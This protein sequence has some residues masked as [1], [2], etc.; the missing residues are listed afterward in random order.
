MPVSLSSANQSIVA[1]ALDV[2]T[3]ALI[4]IGVVSTGEPANAEDAAWGLEKL[5][6]SIDQHNARR[7]MIFSIGLTLFNLQA[8]H[9]PHTIGP[10]GDFNL[11]TRPP[12][13]TAATFILNPGSAN[14][15]D[16]PIRIRDS[17]W[18]AANPLKSLSTSIVT[19]LYYDPALTLGQLNFFPICN[20]AAPVRLEY[21]NAL[22]QAITLQTRLAFVQGYWEA[23]VVDLA[24]KLCPSF[25]IPVSADL[26]EQ[27]NRAMRII[28][29][30]NDGPPRIETNGG[31]PNNGRGGRPDFNFLTG[32]NE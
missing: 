20:V 8:N 7:E 25:G 28:Q 29:A 16:T 5:Q 11:P 24:V 15:V 4:E 6:R 21:W 19:D 14:P 2:A 13:I 26:K 23:I 18:W 10:G 22:Q 1:S 17:D 12:I 32:L 31:M 9:A 30:N 3:S 27:W